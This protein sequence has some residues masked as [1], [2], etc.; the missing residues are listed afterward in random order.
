MWTTV[1]TKSKGD[2]VSVAN[3]ASLVEVTSPH[4]VLQVNVLLQD[5]ASLSLL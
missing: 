5:D 3:W 2:P 4:F 1:G